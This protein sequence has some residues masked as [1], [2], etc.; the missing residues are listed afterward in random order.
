LGADLH[1]YIEYSRDSGKTWQEDSGH[2]ISS[3]EDDSPEYLS[4]KTT[5]RWYLLFGLMAS[6]RGV[7][8]KP[9]G[10]PQNISDFV[11]AA[12]ESYKN[13]GHSHSYM[14][15]NSFKGILTKLYS[16]D[17]RKQTLAE[18]FRDYW[19]RVPAEEGLLNY[20]SIIKYCEDKT[21]DIQ[22]EHILLDN[23]DKVK[24]RIVFWF[25]S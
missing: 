23:P 19:Y 7:G 10:L 16:L 13:D 17:E 18:P 20:Y 12:A 15:L 2:Q 11:R 4:V 3:Y 25:D 6:V 14:S 24:C 21:A 9:R 5:P 1:L 8:R 22:C